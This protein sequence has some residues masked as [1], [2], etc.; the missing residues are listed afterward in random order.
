M[1]AFLLAACRIGAL[2]LGPACC[3]ELARP[4]DPATPCD[5]SIRDTRARSLQFAELCCW[6]RR[7]RVGLPTH[8]WQLGAQKLA[9]IVKQRYP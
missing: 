2:H 9:T 5:L 7:C 1:A 3:T 8:S 4:L 6:P